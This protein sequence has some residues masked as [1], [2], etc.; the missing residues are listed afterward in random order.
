MNRKLDALKEAYFHWLV[1]QVREKEHETRTYWDLLRLMHEKEFVWIVPNDDNRIADALD[2]RREFLHENRNRGD[3]TIE[4]FGPC[5]VLEVL[6][7]LSR[8][9]EFNAPGDA[10][11]EEW[12]WKLI[13]NLRLSG[14][15]DPLSRRGAN[16][17]DKILDA[18]IWRTFHPSGEGGFFPLTWPQQNQAKIEIWA[19]MHAYLNEMAARM[20]KSN[21]Q[22]GRR[23]G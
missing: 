2:L 20:E 5:S 13:N 16:K 18:L 14:K 8:R 19:Q 15:S 3:L 1:S 4:D 23:G 17:V 22:E 12:A 11:A 6:I 21:R 10:T 7:A 9:C